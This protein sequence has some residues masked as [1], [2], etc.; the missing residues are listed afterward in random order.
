MRAIS[1]GYPSFCPLRSSLCLW[2]TS[3]CL[4]CSFPVILSVILAVVGATCTLELLVRRYVCS[5]Q[6]VRCLSLDRTRGSSSLHSLLFFFQKEPPTEGPGISPF[7]SEQ[8]SRLEASRASLCI[9]SGTRRSPSI[10]PSP[11]VTPTLG[12]SPSPTMPDSPSSRSSSR[13]L[14][15]CARSP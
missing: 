1:P 8:P 7:S 14:S 13:W 9:S 3:C 15:A 10:D 12:L 5:P 4:P 6:P 2:L 11:R